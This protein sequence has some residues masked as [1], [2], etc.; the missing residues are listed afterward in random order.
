MDQARPAYL[1]VLGMIV[2]G[3]VIACSSP[4]EPQFPHGAPLDVP[5]SSGGTSCPTCTDPTLDHRMR[6]ADA[7]DHLEI[8]G[9][10][11]YNISQYDYGIEDF[12]EDW[13]GSIGGQHYDTAHSNPYLYDRSLSK[14]H[15]GWDGDDYDANAALARTMVHEFLHH[16]HPEWDHEDMHDRAEYC[17]RVYGDGFET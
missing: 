7:L 13:G 8:V 3:T 1:S 9:R 4:M 10:C 17:A 11:D 16:I 15:I 12:G 2:V 6:M 14:D 5:H